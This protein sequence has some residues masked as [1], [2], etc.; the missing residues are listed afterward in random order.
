VKVVADA[1]INEFVLNFQVKRATPPV[2]LKAANAA[3]GKPAAAAVPSKGDK[4]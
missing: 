1:K 4:A 2:D 3:P